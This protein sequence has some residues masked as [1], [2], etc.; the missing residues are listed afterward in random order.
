MRHHRF[1]CCI[2]A[3]TMLAHGG[4]VASD[5]EK[6]DATAAANKRVEEKKRA[7]DK[8]RAKEADRA[9]ARAERDQKPE[10]IVTRGGFR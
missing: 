1:T 5:A 4:C 2:V 6:K 7:N 8:K 10:E 9:K 3:A